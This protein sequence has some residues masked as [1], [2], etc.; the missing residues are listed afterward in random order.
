MK[1]APQS[2]RHSQPRKAVPTALVGSKRKR[3]EQK[4]KANET[5][6]GRCREGARLLRM[7]KRPPS[8]AQ[9]TVWITTGLSGLA[10]TSASTKGSPTQGS[11]LPNRICTTLEPAR[12]ELVRSC[13]MSAKKENI[14]VKIK[15]NPP[16]LQLHCARTI[17]E[18]RNNR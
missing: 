17:M 18:P 12:S 13:S 10:D 16:K 6:S 7:A 9:H 14:N 3:G 4:D 11:P 15:T 5:D 8:A 1:Y 2:R